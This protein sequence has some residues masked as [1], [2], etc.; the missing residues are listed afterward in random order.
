MNRNVQTR[1]V[2]LNTNAVSISECPN[3]KPCP[4]AVGA[5]RSIGSKSKSISEEIQL[6]KVVIS[7]KSFINKN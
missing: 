6:E 2:K 4:G 3:D 1:G 5:T 7:T